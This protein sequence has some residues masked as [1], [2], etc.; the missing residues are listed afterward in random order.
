MSG[1]LSESCWLAT[2][3][4]TVGKRVAVVLI[5]GKKK[6]SRKIMTRIENDRQNYTSTDCF[7]LLAAQQTAFWHSAILQWIPAWVCHQPGVLRFALFILWMSL[8]LG[9]W[10]RRL[11]DPVEIPTGICGA[12][13]I[14]QTTWSSGNFTARG[15]I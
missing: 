13:G 8:K 12:A 2:W 6:T 1:S 5:I 4:S 10:H 14:P 15:A 11:G 3:C 9:S 7:L